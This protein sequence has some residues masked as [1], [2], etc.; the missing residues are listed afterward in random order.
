ML[1]ISIVKV[2]VSR[3]M[4]QNR[5]HELE[6]QDTRRKLYNCPRFELVQEPRY[7]GP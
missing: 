7:D 6:N 5:A 3:K 4:S 2:A 1:K